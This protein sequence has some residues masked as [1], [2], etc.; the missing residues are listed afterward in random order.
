MAGLLLFAEVP[1]LS[2]SVLVFLRH[3]FV[4]PTFVKCFCDMNRFSSQSLINIGWSVYLPKV[5]SLVVL[6]RQLY[7]GI[8]GT[9][10]KFDG[11]QEVHA[12]HSAFVE[13]WFDPEHHSWLFKKHFNE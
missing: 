2:D 3:G 4:A 7:H 10:R 12:K 8:H 9:E 11:N 6:E 13:L 1:L 5:I